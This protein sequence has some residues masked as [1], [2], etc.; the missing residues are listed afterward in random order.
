MGK[1]SQKDTSPHSEDG[2]LVILSLAVC[3]FMVLLFAVDAIVYH[4]QEKAKQ[5]YIYEELVPEI[6]EEP[7]ILKGVDTDA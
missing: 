4:H 2:I 6:T 7:E 3:I 1:V 5:N